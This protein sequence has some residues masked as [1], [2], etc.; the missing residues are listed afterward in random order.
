MWRRL[1]LSF[2][3]LGLP[4]PR[5]QWLTEQLRGQ[6]RAGLAKAALGS[7]PLARSSVQWHGLVGR[8]R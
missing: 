4:Y 5:Q 8:L 3:R 1:C 6:S 2:L 7:S